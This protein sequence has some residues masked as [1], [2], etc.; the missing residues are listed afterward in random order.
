MEF[1]WELGY[2]CLQVLIA[3]ID[4]APVLASRVVNSGGCEVALTLARVCLFKP[5]G[6]YVQIA[7]TAIQLL[8]HILSQVCMEV[9]IDPGEEEDLANK[10]L[11]KVGKD[12]LGG[13]DIKH[14]PGSRWLLDGVLRSQTTRY[15]KLQATIPKRDQ[16]FILQRLGDAGACE[17]LIDL[18][19]VLPSA[20]AALSAVKLF[21]ALLSNPTNRLRIDCKGVVAR[22]QSVQNTFRSSHECFEFIENSLL[23]KMQG[24]AELET[25]PLGVEHTRSPAFKGKPWKEETVLL[26][27]VALPEKPSLPSP[28][29]QTFG[30]SQHLPGSFQDKTYQDRVRLA[31]EEVMRSTAG[32][33][34]STYSS[35]FGLAK[36]R[37]SPDLAQTL[38]EFPRMHPNGGQKNWMDYA[39]PQPTS[40]MHG[41]RSY[42]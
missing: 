18:F 33:F 16:G 24:S 22:V 17:L 37:S 10:T 26:G 1:D 11:E 25:T 13:L 12:P 42:Y 31:R 23:P 21:D 27:Q 14:K 15:A 8:N 39:R 2:W 5:A 30:W 34:G 20:E 6:G 32:S 28:F 19:P 3:L 36:S 29:R 41:Y 7:I 35:G 38:L 40:Y 4:H 9:Q